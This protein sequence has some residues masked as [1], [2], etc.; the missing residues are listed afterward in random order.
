MNNRGQLAGWEA[1]IIII[2]LAYAGFVTYLWASK[3][4][5]TN[6]FLK[7]S[8]P[9]VLGQRADWPLSFHLFEGGCNRMSK[10]TEP[11]LK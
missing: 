3:T 5:Q 6:N 8:N 7:D 11:T 1:V 9:K 10:Q 2:L 4:S